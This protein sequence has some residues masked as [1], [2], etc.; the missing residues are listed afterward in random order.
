MAGAERK[1]PGRK[2]LAP[3]A[4][5]RVITLRLRPDLE[6]KYIALGGVKWL[7]EA[8]RRARLPAEPPG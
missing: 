8:I 5:Q 7:R 6:A 1:R 4:R 2:P 3:E